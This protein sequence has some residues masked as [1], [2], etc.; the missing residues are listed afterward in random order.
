MSKIDEMRRRREARHTPTD[1]DGLAKVVPIRPDVQ[2]RLEEPSRHAPRD[3]HGK[4]SQCG[5]VKPLQGGVV[6]QHQKG[7][8]KMC[9]GSRKPPA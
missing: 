9:P 1:D 3:E 7:L 2:V 6:A 8:G 4:C 5:K